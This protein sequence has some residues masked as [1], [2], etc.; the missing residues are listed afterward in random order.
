MI[1]SGV[2]MRTERPQPRHHPSQQFGDVGLRAVLTRIVEDGAGGSGAP[3]VTSFGGI[4]RRVSDRSARDL[5]I[6]DAAAVSSGGLEPF[7]V[8]RASTTAASGA[9]IEKAKSSVLPFP[10]VVDTNPLR[11]KYPRLVAGIV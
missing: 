1:G 5:G 7:L 6:H 11:G 4:D 8:F 10:G 2:P 3:I 9:N